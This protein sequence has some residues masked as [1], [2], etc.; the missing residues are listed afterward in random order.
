MRAAKEPVNIE[1]I[2]KQ[3]E[4]EF[5]KIG[6]VV[7]VGVGSVGGSGQTGI[8]VYVKK[9]T[10]ELRQKIPKNIRGIE[11]EIVEVGELEALD[12]SYRC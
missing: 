2:K 8:K 3:S 1:E 6:E 12:E 9:L 4:K 5:L 11:I 7:G 10:V